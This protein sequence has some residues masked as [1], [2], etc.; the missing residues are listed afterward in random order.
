MNTKTQSHR[1]FK[2]VCT[3]AVRRPRSVRV[4]EDS[5]FSFTL[6]LICYRRKRQTETV[7]GF[8]LSQWKSKV[9]FDLYVKVRPAT[10]VNAKTIKTLE[11]G[12]PAPFDRLCAEIQT[13]LFVR[14][15]S[16][17]L[18]TANPSLASRPLHTRTLRSCELYSLLR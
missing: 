14:S 11:M 10:P 4:R 16:P 7:P 2:A 13:S 9:K 8:F 1:K 18:Q 12:Y 17:F 3:L 15:L 5:E 6:C